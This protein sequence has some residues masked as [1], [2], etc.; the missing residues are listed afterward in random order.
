MCMFCAGAVQRAVFAMPKP[1]V[2]DILRGNCLVLVSSVSVIRDATLA[3]F[4][5]KVSKF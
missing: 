5:L 4:G 3:W 2:F 1:C